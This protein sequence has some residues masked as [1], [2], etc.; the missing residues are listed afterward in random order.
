LSE[1]QKELVGLSIF[2]IAS[3]ALFS[4]ADKA[5]CLR[6]ADGR[7]YGVMVYPIFNEIFESN[8]QAAV[9]VAAM[10]GEFDLDPRNDSMSRQTESAVSRRLQH[11]D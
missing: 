10:M 2:R 7:R 3:A 6:F 5:Q 11:F 9:V 8:W 4:D 1:R